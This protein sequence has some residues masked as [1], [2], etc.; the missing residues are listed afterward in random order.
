MACPGH[1]SNQKL[2][3]SHWVSSH[4]LVKPVYWDFS[5][6]AEQH[7]LANGRPVLVTNQRE[8]L[9]THTHTQC[10]RDKSAIT[11]LVGTNTYEREPTRGHETMALA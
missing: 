7:A 5:Q 9:I 10:L 6:I 8:P 1:T 2:T 3:W 4:R 11:D